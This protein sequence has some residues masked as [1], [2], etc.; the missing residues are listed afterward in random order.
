MAALSNGKWEYFAHEVAKGLSPEK[1]YV[2]AGYS[3][4]GARQAANRLRQNVD[5]DARIEEIRNNITERAIEKS[6]VDKSWLL[7]RLADE[8]KADLADL[9]SDNGSIKPINEW[10]E[11]WRTGLVTGF[12]VHQEYTYEQ[13]KKIPDGVMM[14]IKIADRF[15]RLEAIGKHIDVQAFKERVEH[16]GKIGIE[17][18]SDEDLD[19][20]IRRLTKETAIVPADAGE[21]E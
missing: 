1:A 3:E 10:P 19:D 18:L 7:T 8:V 2:A 20:K 4:R 16:S 14:K 5:I 21:S 15:K 11:I 9:F 13:G 12:D 17:D 6:A